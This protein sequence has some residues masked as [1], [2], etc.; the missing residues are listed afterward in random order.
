MRPLTQVKSRR[1]RFMRIQ[2]RA[3][4]RNAPSPIARSC[5][6]DRRFA[7]RWNIDESPRVD[8]RFAHPARPWRRR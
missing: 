5:E 2:S 1:F 7:L 6:L 4:S 8:N 3:N